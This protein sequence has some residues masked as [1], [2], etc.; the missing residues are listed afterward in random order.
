MFLPG[1]LR[2]NAFIKVPAGDLHLAPGGGRGGGGESKSGVACSV[3]LSVTSVTETEAA[4][5]AIF[6]RNEKNKQL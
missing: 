4:D 5:Q 1:E 2:I 3:T 6:L